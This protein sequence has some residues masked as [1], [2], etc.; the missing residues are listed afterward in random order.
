M[1]DAWWRP[2]ETRKEH[3]ERPYLEA[4][5]PSDWMPLEPPMVESADDEETPRVIII[6]I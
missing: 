4:P 5:S 6:D 2:Q 3:V 1:R